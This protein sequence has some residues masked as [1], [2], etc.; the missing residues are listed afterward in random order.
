LTTTAPAPDHM[1]SMS[2]Q[3]RYKHTGIIF[4]AAPPKGQ[5]TSL[6]YKR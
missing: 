1:A 6:R 4:V 5:Q 2:L 3:E